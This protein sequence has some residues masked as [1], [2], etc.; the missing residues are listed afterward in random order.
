MM[1]LR[2]TAQWGSGLEHKWYSRCECAVNF[3][4]T[5][6]KTKLSFSHLIL[7]PLQ[8]YSSHSLT[9]LAVFHELSQC[10]VFLVGGGPEA[11]MVKKKKTKTVVSSFSPVCFTLIQLLFCVLLSVNV[12]HYG[13]PLS[14][15]YWNSLLDTHSRQVQFVLVSIN[16]T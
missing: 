8:L 7:A 5:S 2:S 1:T 16:I 9:Q 12:E 4:L 6:S 15:V 3:Q 11:E 14:P 13:Q 10:F